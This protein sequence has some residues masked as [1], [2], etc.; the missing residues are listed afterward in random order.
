MESCSA[1]GPSAMTSGIV[2]TALI[3]VVALLVP[4]QMSKSRNLDEEIR[5]LNAQEVDGLLNQNVKSL[6]Y[7]WS[8]DLVVT[9]PLNQFVN[10]EKVIELVRSGTLAFVS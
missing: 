9:N 8:K 7:L 5:R 1:K 2:R 4:M 6:E 3:T 10:K